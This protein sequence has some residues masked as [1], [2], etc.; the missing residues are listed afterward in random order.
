VQEARV[1]KQMLGEFEQ[2]VM[3]AIL[4]VRGDAYGVPIV[5]EIEARTG[6]SV[7]PASVHV[8]LRRLEEKGLI[9]TWLSEPVAERGGRARRCVRV[10]PEGLRQLRESRSMM[11]ALWS[12]VELPG[13]AR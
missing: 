7:A 8:T 4:R 10:E 3:L 13:E 9:T 12:G 11:D 6:R 5:E 2:M 1:S